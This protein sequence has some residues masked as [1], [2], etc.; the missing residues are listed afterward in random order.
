MFVQKISSSTNFLQNAFPQNAH[1]VE[2]LIRAVSDEREAGPIYWECLVAEFSQEIELC[3]PERGTLIVAVNQVLIHP[4]HEG[5]CECVVGGPKTRDHRLCA[6]QKESA[7][8]ARD[9]LLTQKSSGTRVASGKRYQF[10][11]QRE[12]PNLARLQKAVVNRIERAA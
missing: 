9:A 8:Q 12:I 10:G 5:D 7:F 11:V 3:L 1:S 6:G 2:D 4:F